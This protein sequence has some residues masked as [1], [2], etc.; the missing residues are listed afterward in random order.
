MTFAVSVILPVYNE[1]L[2]ARVVCEEVSAFA[3]AHLEYRFIFVDDG[4]TDRTM[5]ILEQSIP[6]SLRD[7]V[8]V[9]GHAIN[10]GKGYAI[11]QG[12]RHATGFAVILMDGDLAYSLQLLP[13]FVDN[14]GH[15]DAV[16]GVRSR[17]DA[18]NF[19]RRILGL[20]F[21]QIARFMFAINNRDTQAG[22]KGLT[23]KAAAR[24]MPALTCSR[25]AFDVELIVALRTL[26]LSIK[27]L[28]VKV[29]ADHHGKPSHVRLIAD[30]LQMLA[31]L[32]RIK[33]LQCFGKYNRIDLC[34]R[35]GEH[36][37]TGY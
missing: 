25:F 27:E 17:T 11:R 12:F 20:G 9:I 35:I 10:R 32:C 28:E 18:R 16:L 4:S 26:N 19:R 14:L 1:E 23:L 2:V 24:V 37:Q 34:T 30:S 5:L 3:D 29:E 31:D 7:R 22:I 13:A 8:I 33:I 36:S 21:H 15:A 6:D